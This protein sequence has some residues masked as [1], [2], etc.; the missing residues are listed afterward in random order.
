MIWDPNLRAKIFVVDSSPNDYEQ[1]VESSN[2]AGTQVV[3][4][5]SGRAALQAQAADTP[6][7]WIVN[8]R[9]SDMSGIDLQSMLRSCGCCAPIALVGDEYRPSDEITARC[10]GADLYFAK[11]IQHDVLGMTA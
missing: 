2:Q 4:F 6:A 11:P 10:A 5:E 7:M 9:L 3:F 1:L 8:L